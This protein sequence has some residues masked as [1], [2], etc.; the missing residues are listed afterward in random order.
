MQDENKNNID[1]KTNKVSDTTE[2][3]IQETTEASVKTEQE[4]KE[5]IESMNDTMAKLKGL[6]A[7]NNEI[8][9]QSTKDELG[10]D[11]TVDETGKKVDIDYQLT[12]EELVVDNLA[13]DLQA[14]EDDI[15]ANKKFA[16]LAYILFFIPLCINAKSP[17]IRLH[18]NEGLDVFFIDLF[19]SIL[20]VCGVVIKFPIDLAI[21]GYLMIIFSVGLFI[22]TT[23]TKIF[24]IIQVCRGKQ[25]QT[26]W[27]W[28]TRFI[29]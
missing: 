18:A 3:E 12:N 29:K 4:K 9:K 7:K 1:I 13:K 19:A 6:I 5:N 24:Q 21:V 26:P 27:L 28:K 25:N 16:W 14:E 17:F 15:K 22:L 20:M 11:Y 8:A 23:I 10:S 2:V